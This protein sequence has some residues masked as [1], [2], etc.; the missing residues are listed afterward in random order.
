MACLCL[1]AI[2]GQA[3][4]LYSL[5]RY[6]AERE[7]WNAQK[8]QFASVQSEWNRLSQQFTG[9]LGDLKQQKS[10]LAAEIEKLEEDR[11]RLAEDL[12]KVRGQFDSIAQS[13]DEAISL[14]HRA[15]QQQQQALDAEQAAQARTAELTKSHSTVQRD[16]DALKMELASLEKA[17]QAN[18]LAVDQQKTAIGKQAQELADLAMRLTAGRD[19]LRKQNADL[20]TVSDELT[21]ALAAKQMAIATGNAVVDESD[22]L[23]KTREELALF[24]GKVVAMKSERDA[25][26][27]ELAKEQTRLQ[28]AK[29][30][31]ADYLEQWR[32]RETITKQVATLQLEIGKLTKS[33]SDIEAL[34]QRLKDEQTRAEQSATAKTKELSD[35]QSRVDAL[36]NEEGKLAS[37]LLERIKALKPGSPP[38][39]KEDEK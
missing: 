39:G 26:Q 3:T 11:K 2:A 7:G 28:N 12:A 22:R 34:V 33:Q 14:Q 30:K 27:S 31:L 9:D 4:G 1:V 37:A 18:R 13:R 36:R 15:Q 8:S 21:K 5:V 17:A 23:T 20:L 16:I 24:S 10:A 38:E 35:L 32:T 6:G 25:V 19:D 29:D